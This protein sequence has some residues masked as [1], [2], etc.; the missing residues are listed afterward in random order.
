MK[1]TRCQ[2]AVCRETVVTHRAVP[3]ETAAGPAAQAET[4]AQRETES[5]VRQ[6]TGKTEATPPVV[7]VLRATVTVRVETAAG[8]ETDSTSWPST[9][10]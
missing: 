9:V 6:R 10:F 5:G 2:D 3:A 4:A 1:Q 7:A 8:R